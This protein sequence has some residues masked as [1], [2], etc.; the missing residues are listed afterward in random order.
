MAEEF[1]IDQLKIGL[2]GNLDASKQLIIQNVTL[3]ILDRIYSKYF[4]GLDFEIEEINLDLGSLPINHFTEEYAVRLSF[5]LENEIK[6][7]LAEN[8]KSIEYQSSFGLIDEIRHYFTYGFSFSNEISFYDLFT[9]GLTKDY[10][11]LYLAISEIAAQEIVKE[12]LLKQLDYE[13][14]EVLWQLNF[15]D[16]VFIKRLNAALSSLNFSRND[17]STDIQ[18]L[19]KE[20]TIAFMLAPYPNNKTLRGYLK[21]LEYQIS[22]NKKLKEAEKIKVYG[23]L[24]KIESG[25]ISNDK[26]FDLPLLFD[27]IYL[28]VIENRQAQYVD[29]E[30]MINASHELTFSQIRA[31]ASSLGTKL[32]RGYVVK[33]LQ[34]LHLVLPSNY[35]FAFY[36]ALSVLQKG[37][38]KKKINNILLI[39]SFSKFITGFYLKDINPDMIASYLSGEVSIEN[40]FQVFSLKSGRSVINLID[41][42]QEKIYYNNQEENKNLFFELNELRSTIEADHQTAIINKPLFG[43]LIEFLELGIWNNV[44]FSPQEVF[45]KIRQSQWLELIQEFKKYFERPIFWTRFVYQFKVDQVE[46]MIREVFHEDVDL[47]SLDAI[48]GQL[49]QSEYQLAQKRKVLEAFVRLKFAEQNQVDFKFKSAFEKVVFEILFE[50][51]DSSSL[52]VLLSELLDGSKAADELT[53][54]ELQQIKSAENEVLR[55]LFSKN[56]S[57][58]NWKKI[59]DLLQSKQLGKLLANLYKVYY[60]KHSEHFS[61]VFSNDQFLN[62]LKHDELMQAIELTAK[63]AHLALIDLVEKIFNRLEKRKVQT[64]AALQ[65][66]FEAAINILQ[67]SNESEE[68]DHFTLLDNVLENESLNVLK[69]YYSQEE[70]EHVIINAFQL[71]QTQTRFI[72]RKHGALKTMGLLKVFSSTSFKLLL[73]KT[74]D[75]LARDLGDLIFRLKSANSSQLKIIDLHV[76]VF[77]LTAEVYSKHH[78]LKYISSVLNAAVLPYHE[79]DNEQEIEQQMQIDLLLDYLETGHLYNQLNTSDFKQYAWNA[80]S[81]NGVLLRLSIITRNDPAMLMSSFLQLFSDNELP[82][83]FSSLCQ[84][85]VSLVLNVITEI[86]SQAGN[87][88]AAVALGLWFHLIEKSPLNANLKS[89][90]DYI[91]SCLSQLINKTTYLQFFEIEERINSEP[92][93]T[94]LGRDS[95]TVVD[96]Q[97]EFNLIT[98][99]LQKNQLPKWP[100]AKIDQLAKRIFYFGKPS[101]TKN[102]FLDQYQ[103][104]QLERIFSKLAEVEIEAVKAVLKRLKREESNFNLI[105]ALNSWYEIISRNKALISMRQDYELATLL[106]AKKL[107]GEPITQSDVQFESNTNEA[108]WF[109]YDQINLK[110]LPRELT[111][112][113]VSSR[114]Q[115]DFN[116][117]DLLDYVLVN[118][119]LPYWSD[120]DLSNHFLK[121]LLLIGRFI[122]AQLK[123]MFERVLQNKKLRS[124]C[125]NF[126]GVEQ[127]ILI[128]SRLKIL[129]VERFKNAF[130]QFDELNKKISTYN[131]RIQFYLPR[132]TAITSIL[133][134]TDSAT[135]NSLIM[136]EFQEHLG[137]TR[138]EYQIRLNPVL[139]L[140]VLKYNELSK[141]IRKQDN[142]F[143][144]AFDLLVHFSAGTAFPWW[145]PQANSQQNVEQTAKAVITELLDLD[146]IKLVDMVGGS[147]FRTKIIEFWAGQLTRSQLDRITIALDPN[148]GGFIVSFNLLVEKIDGD[149]MKKSWINMLLLSLFKKEVSTHWI[150]EKGSAFWAASTHTSVVDFKNNLLEKAIEYSNNGESRFS[151]FVTLLRASTHQMSTS[152]IKLEYSDFAEAAIIYLA[153]KKYY[154]EQISLKDLLIIGKDLSQSQIEQ[155]HRIELSRKL[156]L[157]S[158][159]NRLFTSEPIIFLKLLI[160]TI[161]QEEGSNLIQNETLSINIVLQFYPEALQSALQNAYYQFLFSEY[162]ESLTKDW[163]TIVAEFISNQLKNLEIEEQHFRGISNVLI[164]S[165]KLRTELK[166]RLKFS[167][168]KDQPLSTKYELNE[169]SLVDA[170]IFYVE[171]AL[172]NQ[173]VADV[174]KNETGLVLAL[175]QKIKKTPINW[176]KQEL[177]KLFANEAFLRKALTRAPILVSFLKAKSI[178]NNHLADNTS[179]NFQTKINEELDY[180]IQL[181][182]AYDDNLS[183]PFY[184]QNDFFIHYIRTGTL[185]TDYRIFFHSK[186]DFLLSF[187]KLV[188][189]SKPSFSQQIKKVLQ[190]EAVRMR[191][192]RNEDEY[193]IQLLLKSL[194]LPVAKSLVK[195][196][197]DIISFWTLYAIEVSKEV[198]IELFYSH[199]MEILSLSKDVPKA[200][201]IETSLIAKSLNIFQFNEIY[202]EQELEDFGF[203]FEQK[204]LISKKL[205]KGFTQSKIPEE[206]ASG[207][208]AVIDKQIERKKEEIKDLIPDITLDIQVNIFNAGLVILWPYIAQLFKMLHLTDKNEFVSPE[209]EIKAVHILQYAA[210]GLE[211]AEEHHL[212]LN[213]VLCGVK[214]ATPI[215]FEMELT[216]SDK[217]LTNQMLKGVLQNW[218]RL[219]NTSIEA[220]RETF[221]MREGMLDETEKNFQLKVEKKTLDI[222]LESMPWSFGMIKLPWMQKRLLVEWI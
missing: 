147:P 2:S 106:L 163:E 198:Q 178:I 110:N 179:D 23:Q 93:N 118:A 221:L 132:Y 44:E 38:Y 112:R 218:N 204:E 146:P 37:I 69:N 86:G 12:R 83:I 186:T 133:S 219:N 166:K 54:K 139:T 103:N 58:K 42:F 115:G 19:L 208:F 158:I 14:A 173:S 130:A 157:P 120:F 43:Q 50:D 55:F 154:K 70:F 113:G 129:N 161:Y 127:S 209:A 40:V 159:Q 149:F 124:N 119:K 13:L 165:K 64:T 48:L 150:L 135:I 77:A 143:D 164:Q 28:F 126:F 167:P 177:E 104:H 202:K 66:G 213:K 18:A 52:I 90:V 35:R 207:K 36:D 4:I 215:P 21:F 109:N 10:K 34:R 85:E 108:L 205:I 25:S 181:E 220:M 1:I 121:E 212:L 47:K 29:Y 128:F 102:E 142:G 98:F 17:F 41:H 171:T 148:L 8:H 46:D 111:F 105:V 141:Q 15:P 96:E 71:F 89:K 7:F 169:T 222:L 210:S 53:N 88:T 3:E 75:V 153:S 11:S 6:K 176:L 67:D 184:S 137:F 116:F 56:R 59:L 190:D 39:S 114:F 211:E 182:S 30:T 134:S 152:T 16:Y 180:S 117:L 22:I 183:I 172:I 49:G 33:N 201:K 95:L 195:R 174:I 57:L 151:P 175:S 189:L 194:N 45:T 9:Q 216:E 61:R 99:I 62:E 94:S 199:S 203:S 191:V 144:K 160:C 101:N 193:F 82:I 107:R 26:G 155:K 197:N 97:N 100:E 136:R 92:E 140:T 162:K 217:N 170:V 79:L 84:I 20:A 81:F 65:L 24:N 125:I 87:R 156:S 185:P 74:T 196:R 138:S 145:Y 123:V 72:F 76:L 214:L 78:F 51:S 131:F 73:R 206:Q 5:L 63:G 32:F 80:A 188:M 187:E 27:A 168:S 91:V 68:Y 60:F 31:L 200:S 122:P 192:I